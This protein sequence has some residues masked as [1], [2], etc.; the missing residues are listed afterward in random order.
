MLIETGWLNLF[1]VDGSG[2]EPTAMGS[3]LVLREF[4]PNAP[5]AP[6]TDSITRFSLDRER[7]TLLIFR[8]G[9]RD[10][11]CCLQ[12]R[13]IVVGQTPRL[14]AASFRLPA[15]YRCKT[16]RLIDFS[17]FPRFLSKGFFEVLVSKVII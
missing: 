1:G 6:W 7:L 5:S 11:P 2:R 10:I 16:S 15:K 17:V 13:F 12:M 4:K 8:D 14:F 3:G 9:Q